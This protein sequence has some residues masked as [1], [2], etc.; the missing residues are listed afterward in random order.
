M[1]AVFMRYADSA[2]NEMV[3]SKNKYLNWENIISR[4][5]F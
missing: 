3:F 4:N 5:G 2:C 1:I